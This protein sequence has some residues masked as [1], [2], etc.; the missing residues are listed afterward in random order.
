MATRFNLALID[1]ELP[2]LSGLA[3]ARAA[4]NHGTPVVMLA[5]HP[6]MIQ[7]M[8]LVGLPH[9]QKPF[10]MAELLRKSKNA[11]ASSRETLSRYARLCLSS[12]NVP[13]RFKLP[14]KSLDA[15]SAK[16]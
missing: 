13:E 3:V 6:D 9:L 14:W 11:V 15:C 10:R 12:D 16:V 1:V 7:K 2:G 8:R 4:V 5:G